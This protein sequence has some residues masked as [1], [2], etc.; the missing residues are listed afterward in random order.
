M[1]TRAYTSSSRS[2]VRSAVTNLA[3]EAIPFAGLV[4]EEVPTLPELE[5]A[6]PVAEADIAPAPTPT[7]STDAGVEGAFFEAAPRYTV[8]SVA[9]PPLV[10]APQRSPRRIAKLI[11]ASLGSVVVLLGAVELVLACLR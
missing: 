3:P 11:F 8:T 5:A 2:G 1:P 7:A 9:P 6:A 4:A 10:V